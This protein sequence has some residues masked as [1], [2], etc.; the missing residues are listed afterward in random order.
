MRVMTESYSLLIISICG[1]GETHRTRIFFDYSLNVKLFL[2]ILPKFYWYLPLFEAHYLAVI[3]PST[4]M[5]EPTVDLD[6]SD[7]R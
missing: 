2:T 4:T 1:E 3:P 6:S 7:A 5:T